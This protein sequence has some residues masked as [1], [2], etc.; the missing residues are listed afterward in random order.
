[1]GCCGNIPAGLFNVPCVIES[2]VRT[3]DSRGAPKE[4]W[5][6][7]WTGKAMVK[8]KSGS[9]KEKSMGIDHLTRR[10]ATIRYISGVDQTMRILVKGTPNNIAW[11]NN[12]DEQD[13]YLEIT[14]QEN[15]NG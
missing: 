6:T 3:K 5:T 15:V 4:E 11:L 13:E 8:T 1:M 14:I 10:V 9:E 7:F 2:K 12:M